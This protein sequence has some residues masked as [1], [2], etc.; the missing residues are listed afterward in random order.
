MIYSPENEPI[1]MGRGHQCDLRVSDISVSRLHAYIKFENGG[2][3]MYDNNSKFGSL[4]KL[5]KPI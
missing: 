1:K 4:V 5:T 2:F 3:V